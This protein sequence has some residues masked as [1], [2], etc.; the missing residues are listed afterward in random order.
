[1]AEISAMKAQIAELK[2]GKQMAKEEEDNDQR[3]VT[4]PYSSDQEIQVAKGI[5][6]PNFGFRDMR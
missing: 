3:R 6:D 5:N 4:A 1:M 2:K